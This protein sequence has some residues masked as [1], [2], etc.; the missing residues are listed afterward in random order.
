MLL[1]LLDACRYFDLLE[2]H[3]SESFHFL[4]REKLNAL[5]AFLCICVASLISFNIIKN[6]VQ[7]SKQRNQQLCEY[8]PQADA[9]SNQNEPSTPCS[10]GLLS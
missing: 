1:E 7:T 8:R 4:T 9:A 2:K 6:E 5:V 10:T 3:L